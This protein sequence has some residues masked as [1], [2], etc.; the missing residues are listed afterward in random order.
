VRMLGILSIALLVALVVHMMARGQ[1]QA[2][3]TVEARSRELQQS[4]SQLESLVSQLP[5]I[6]LRSRADA[7]WTPIVAAGR[8]RET[9]GFSGDEIVSGAAG[10]RGRIDPADLEAFSEGLRAAL[11]SGQSFEATY[12]F[13][14][15]DG[16][17]HWLLERARGVVQA[18][19]AGP[20][21]DSIVLDITDLRHAQEERQR[22]ERKLLETQKL[23]SLG[24]LAGGVAHDFNN[25][26]T[27]IVGHAELA[28]GGLA[29]GTAELESVRQIE[30]A[31]LRAGELCRQLLAYAGKGTF[32][33]A[34]MDLGALARETLPLLTMSVSK[35]VR[36]DVQQADRPVYVMADATQIRQILMNLVINASDAIGDRPG[37]VTIRM[38]LV[39]ADAELL[40][41]CAAGADLAPGDFAMLQVSDTGCGMPAET[42]DRIFDPFYTTKFTG[43]G[44]GLAAVLG[45][46]RGHH[47]A[48]HVTSS[49]GAGSQFTLFLP[50]TIPDA[51]AADPAGSQPRRF[52]CAGRALIIDDEQAVREITSRLLATFGFT[53]ETAASGEEGL[54][55][56]LA[57]TPDDCDVV[58]LDLVMPGMSGEETLRRIRA[59]RPGLRVLLVSGYSEA[60]VV[61]PG[62]GEGPVGFL[63]KPFNRAS[64][65]Q[66]LRALWSGA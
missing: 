15:R 23:E 42:L 40:A 9:V 25:L 20:V 6:A 5:G 17:T 46:V 47:G 62:P 30:A 45:I 8:P 24:V 2:E 36:I 13:Q 44:L 39:R 55:R 21:V 48:L 66:Q 63:G 41:R 33:I 54:A 12:R 22:I 65:E 51:E 38:G 60:P 61:A 11:A 57:G 64:L 56:L 3:E 50:R 32:R 58:L 18:G 29:P 1:A 7:A 14:H 35:Q 4:R 34:V 26:L 10:F 27:G 19:D 31:A 49:E 53:A 37:V 16:S 59:I 52:Y 43:R 28:S